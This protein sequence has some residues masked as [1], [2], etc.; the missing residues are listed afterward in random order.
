MRRPRTHRT[1]GLAAARSRRRVVVLAYDRVALFELAIAIEVFG[2]PRPELGVPWYEFAVCSLEPGALRAT[3]AIEIRPSGGLRLLERADTIVV[4]GWR[5]PR[6]KPPAR[7]LQALRR[8]H[9]RGARLVS[10]CSGVFVLAAAGVLEGKRA[11]THWR[12]TEILRH[13]FPSIRVEP[14]V[15][16]V[17]DGQV[18]TSAGSAAG[19]DLC[20]HLVRLDYGADIANQVARRL[21]VPPHRDGGQAQYIDRPV[22]RD[23]GQGLA[24]ALEWAL[25]HLDEA[26]GVDALAGAAALSPR[27]FLR[28]FQAELGTTPHA[29]LNRQRVLAAQRLLESS[30]ASVD[31]VAASVGFGTAQTLRLQFRRC[32]RTSPTAYRRQFSTR[33]NRRSPRQN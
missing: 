31:E 22:P 3:G 23:A 30:R 28:R 25:A 15:L 21:V 13:L 26:V 27:T 1:A 24:R 32:L 14:D 19:I 7:L 8:A 10:I 6:E 2:L 29:W 4:P 12:Y 20:L 33:G 5:D 9:A 16:H 17:D 18:F 11:T